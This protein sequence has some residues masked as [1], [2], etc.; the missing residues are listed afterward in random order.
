VMQ[1]RRPS[2][3]LTPRLAGRWPCAVNG[4]PGAIVSL[5]AR[6]G[7]VALVAPPAGGPDAPV[8]LEIH[9]PS[10]ARLGL[11]ARVVRREGRHLALAWDETDAAGLEALGRFI[12]SCPKPP[13]E[14]RWSWGRPTAART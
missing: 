1:P 5:S 8:R 4:Q 7:L 12:A 3:R 6:G 14:R 10:G 9:D 2:R 13:R 11:P